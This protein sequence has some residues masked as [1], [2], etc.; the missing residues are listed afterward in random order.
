MKKLNTTKVNKGGLDGRTDFSEKDVQQGH[1]KLSTPE[2]L[3]SPKGKQSK[4]T[5]PDRP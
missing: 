4:G 3:E 1:K 5:N 2:L